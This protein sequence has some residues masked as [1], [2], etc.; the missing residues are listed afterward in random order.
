[1]KVSLGD[2]NND[3]QPEMVAETGN[4]YISETMKDTIEI[5]TANLEFTT[6]DRRNYR[7][8]NVTAA[9]KRKQTGA[10]R[11][12]PRAIGATP[13]NRKWQYRSFGRQSCHFGLSLIVAIT[14]HN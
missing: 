1:M 9:Y 11:N 5:S 13:D 6:K 7:Q 10:R 2:S 8:V 14:W 12:G 3:R 4:T